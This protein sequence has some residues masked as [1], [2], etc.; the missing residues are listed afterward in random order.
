MKHI[1]QIARPVW[2]ASLILGF[3]SLG[4]VVFAAGGIDPS[5]KWAWS[6]N[7]GWINFAPEFG[8]VTVYR[9]H[10]EGYIW[11]ENI[12]WIR[13]GTYTGGGNHPYANTAANNYGINRDN[14]GYLFGYAW[15]TNVGWINF[16]PIN[17]GVI[18]DPQTGVFSGYAWGENIGWIST[19]GTGYGIVTDFRNYRIF[20]PLVIR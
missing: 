12:G 20:L 8:G 3:L 1:L 14:S 13:L 5:S 2:V 17:G 4:Q 18:I 6:T 11:S 9:D 16:A 19:K 10:L 7:T 15:G